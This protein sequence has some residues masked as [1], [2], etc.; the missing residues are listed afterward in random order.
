MRPEA[1][2]GHAR[3]K[4]VGCLVHSSINGSRLCGA[5]VSSSALLRTKPVYIYCSK[6]AAAAAAD[7][8]QR[9]HGWYHHCYA[10]PLF[11]YIS[12]IIINIEIFI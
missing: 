8:V 4:T 10:K 1:S 3:R 11:L 7:C 5:R 12:Y 2:S 6:D 9:A